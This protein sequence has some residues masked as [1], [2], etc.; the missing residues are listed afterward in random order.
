[1]RDLNEKKFEWQARF[2]T[3]IY[4]T[5]FY[6]LALIE[7][8]S[9]ILLLFVILIDMEADVIV[10]WFSFDDVEGVSLVRREIFISW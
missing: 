5:Q 1:M 4:S 10:R 9:V 2:S 3:W 8:K 7:R 6:Y